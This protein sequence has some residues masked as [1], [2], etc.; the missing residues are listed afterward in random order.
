MLGIPAVPAYDSDGVEQALGHH[1]HTTGARHSQNAAHLSAGTLRPSLTGGVIPHVGAMPESTG[2]SM[3]QPRRMSASVVP[4]SMPGVSSYAT[5]AS[6]VY[7]DPSHI[8]GPGNREQA[9]FELRRMGMLVP[10]R[11]I[12]ASF[13]SDRDL[14][15]SVTS[16]AFSGQASSAASPQ[17]RGRR[18]ADDWLPFLPQQNG[19]LHYSLGDTAHGAAL[20]AGQTHPH[21]PYSGESGSWV[22]RHGGPQSPG[23]LDPGPFSPQFQR[24]SP[25]PPSGTFDVHMHRNAAHRPGHVARRNSASGSPASALLSLTPHPRSA[26]GVTHRRSSLSTVAALLVSEREKPMVNKSGY[27]SGAHPGGLRPR[28]SQSLRDAAAPLDSREE[29]RR[30]EPTFYGRR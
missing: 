17:S 24:P 26:N 22:V 25:L 7:R 18:V 2:I 10:G 3:Q 12:A 1:W 11:P 4:M 15:P 30:G 23:T 28:P 21:V 13:I 5:Q 6:P 8:T 9:Q 14:P 27:P 29:L 20:S 16:H 19:V